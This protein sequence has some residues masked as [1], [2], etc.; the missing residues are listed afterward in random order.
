MGIVSSFAFAKTMHHDQRRKG[1]GA[2]FIAHPMAVAALVIEY[3]GYD[4]EDEVV[5]AAMLHDIIEDTPVLESHLAHAFTPRIARMVAE[6][7]HDEETTGKA[8]RQIYIDRMRTTHDWDVVLIS[9]CDK[10]DNMRSIKH[11]IRCC[12]GA[13]FKHGLWFYEELLKVYKVRELPETLLMEFEDTL[14]SV[15]A[16]YDAQAV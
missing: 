13:E 7:S 2:A 16:M 8:K 12:G 5:R 10:L 3:G 14:S 15:Q 9:A 4:P 1:F 6:L 11:M